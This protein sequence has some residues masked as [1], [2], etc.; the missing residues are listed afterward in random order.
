MEPEEWKEF[1]LRPAL[2]LSL[3]LSANGA[4]IYALKRVKTSGREEGEYLLKGGGDFLFIFGGALITRIL[5]IWKKL[6]IFI[7]REY[8][9]EI[10]VL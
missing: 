7:I 1:H 9:F 2:S 3:S 8:N 4:A 10:F 5:D 6:C